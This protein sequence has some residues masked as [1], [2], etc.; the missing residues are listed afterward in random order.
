V[1]YVVWD[2][3]S[4]QRSPHFAESLQRYVDRYSGR[5]VH[6]QSARVDKDGRQVQTPLIIVY[7][8]RP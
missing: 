2:T 4:A 7:E 1:Q 3:F 5:E 6:R 8:V